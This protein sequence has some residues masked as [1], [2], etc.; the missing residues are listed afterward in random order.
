MFF[1]ANVLVILENE[2][3]LNGIF[4]FFPLNKNLKK[5]F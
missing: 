4:S 5:L 3:K 1:Y 2:N